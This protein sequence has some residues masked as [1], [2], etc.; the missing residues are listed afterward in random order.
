MVSALSLKNKRDQRFECLKLKLFPGVESPLHITDDA[1]C[2]VDSQ[3]LIA[4]AC[5]LASF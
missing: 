3:C 4:F 5:L 1:V 2:F